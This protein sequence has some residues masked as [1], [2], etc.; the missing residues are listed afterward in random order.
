MEKNLHLK[1]TEAEHKTIRLMAAEEGI[2]MKEV[3]LRGL[4]LLKNMNLGAEKEEE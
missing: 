2:S 4:E 3:L 1:L